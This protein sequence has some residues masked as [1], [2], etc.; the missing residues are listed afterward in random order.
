MSHRAIQST[1]DVYAQRVG[2]A[3]LATN[4]VRPADGVKNVS[5]YANVTTTR[6]VM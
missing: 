5:I 3:P 4:P 2:S 6:R 1:A